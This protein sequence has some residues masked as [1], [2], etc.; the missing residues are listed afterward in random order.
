[1]PHRFQLLEKFAF[2]LVVMFGA[3]CFALVAYDT[4]PDLQD[5]VQVGKEV[6][7]KS[8]EYAFACSSD[9][10]ALCAQLTLQ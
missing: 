8:G 6:L 7:R 2:S 1:M 5:S 9:T 4:S 3:A 10:Q